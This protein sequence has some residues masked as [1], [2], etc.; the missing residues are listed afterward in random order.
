MEQ[1]LLNSLPVQIADTIRDWCKQTNTQLDVQS[2][3][4][5]MT[6]NF[7]RLYRTQE[8]DYLGDD[9]ESVADTMGKTLTQTQVA[10]IADRIRDSEWYCSLDNES[11]QYYIEEVTGDK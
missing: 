7:W 11:V 4:D 2:L 3:A 5:H 8:L 1:Q 6:K 10:N 9:V